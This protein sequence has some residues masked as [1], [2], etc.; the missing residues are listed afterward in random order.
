MPTATMTSTDQESILLKDFLDERR[1]P[2][3]YIHIETNGEEG[4][5][6]RKGLFQLDGRNGIIT[7]A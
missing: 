7:L 3:I 1:I 4:K 6:V 2:Y 5:K